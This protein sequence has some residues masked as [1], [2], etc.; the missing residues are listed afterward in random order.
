MPGLFAAAD[1][2]DSL[3]RR[4]FDFYASAEDYFAQPE[5]QEGSRFHKALLP[6]LRAL[7]GERGSL[8]LLEVG[9]GRSALPRWL[10][11]L[12]LGVPLHIAVQDVT[13]INEAHLRAAADEVLIGPLDRH[14]LASRFD[15]VLST[16]VYEHVARPRQFL[17]QCLLALRP[18][19]KLVLFSPKY[20]LPGYVP[21]SLRHLPLAQRH[22]ATLRSSLRALWSRLSGRPA[23][24]VVR[25]PAVFE[26]TWFRDAD[27]VHLVHPIDARLHLRNRA[28]ADALQVDV[29]SFKDWRWQRAALHAQV[30]TKL[31]AAPKQPA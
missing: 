30:F 20:V 4:L 6:L 16:F 9:A 10:R 17:D 12:D 26:G 23:F 22:L 2:I 25:C 1:E 21:P 31:S 29:L 15:L 24:L 11:S 7:A 18:D 8:S 3:E 13:P 5:T 27:A 14:G 19:G 28:E